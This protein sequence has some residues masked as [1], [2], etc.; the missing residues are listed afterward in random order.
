MARKP[1]ICPAGYPQH[2]IQRGNN[3]SVCFASDDDYIAYAH[4]LKEGAEKY[5]IAVHAWVLM[6]NHVHLLVTPSEDNTVSM[7]MQYLGRYYVRRFNFTYKRTG[8]LWEGRYKSSLVDSN[9]YV[10][11]CYRY[12][13]MN[14]V[15]ANMVVSPCDYR[16]SSYHANARGIDSDLQTPHPCYLSL[17][18]NKSQRLRAYRQ[19]FEQPD[20]NYLDAEIAWGVKKGLATGSAKFKAEIE[21]LT[22][23]AQE[24]QPRG[25]KKGFKEEF[26]L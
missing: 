21:A 24:L 11:A 18:S 25:P 14:P 4:W 23:V 26:L 20:A 8:T 9:R 5:G 13:E 1:R 19:L 6:T 10:V 12:I 2:I 3:R 7:L 22:A 16:W 17:G 15:V